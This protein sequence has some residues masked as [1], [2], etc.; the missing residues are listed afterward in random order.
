MQGHSR[1]FTCLLEFPSYI[2]TKTFD[3]IKCGLKVVWEKRAGKGNLVNSIYG[4]CLQNILLYDIF[5]QLFKQYDLGLGVGNLRKRNF[6]Q[7]GWNGKIIE[8]AC[9]ANTYLAVTILIIS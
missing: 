8:I 7:S 2:S 4:P 1:N 6:T 5:W 3:M 9:I